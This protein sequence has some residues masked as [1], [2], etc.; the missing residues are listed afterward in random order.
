M[1]PTSRLRLLLD[2][3]HPSQAHIIRAIHEAGRAR[4]HEMEVLA[5]DKD[6][7][8]ALLR[9]F[10]IPFTSLSR[11][12]PGRL[13]AA[14]ELVE[15][16]LRFY[17]VVRRF[18]PHVLLGTSVHAARAS[19][20]FGG[21]AVVLNEDDASVVPLFTRIAYP[22]AHRIVTPDSLRHEDWGSRHR[23][24]PG[25]QKLF[26]LHRDRFS[27]DAEVPRQAGLH[28]PFGLVRLSGLAAHHDVGQRGLDPA[29][30]SDLAARLRGRVEVL[31]STEKPG[32]P[33]EGTRQLK[34]PPE[35]VHHVMAAARFVVSDSQSMTVE[36][37]LLGVPAIR[38]SDFAGRISTLKEL[39]KRDLAYSF[40]PFQ[41]AQAMD[42]VASIANDE[43]ARS[44]L[45]EAHNRY[46]AGMP[47]PLPWL[48]DL[49]EELA[50]EA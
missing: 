19:R 41:T 48:M 36:A 2:V 37:A 40:L 13:G 39:E 21:K 43:A 28:A 18:R 23:T 14:L 22:G 25:T 30:V 32:S 33:P 16:E 3:N 44:R 15:R 24:Y 45:K 5:R 31:V 7:T 27:A 35:C 6:V 10:G 26:Y 12:R 9:A 38:V 42:L 47:D 50:K 8:L 20:L 4:G 34:V 11:P 49:V 1:S 46:F 29:A 17:G